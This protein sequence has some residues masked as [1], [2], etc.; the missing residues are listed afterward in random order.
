MTNLPDKSG[1]YYW[2]EK[3]GDKWE[4]GNVFE[5]YDCREQCLYFETF[6]ISGK[7]VVDMGGQWLPVPTADE[8]VE[9]QA[10][11]KMVDEGHEA[12]AV[13]CPAGK[14]AY[15]GTQDEC[16]RK[17]ADL[18]GKP[19]RR[20]YMPTEADSLDYGV[21]SDDKVRYHMHHLY[22]GDHSE[23]WI[24]GIDQASG[25]EISRYPASRVTCIEWEVPR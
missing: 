12:W 14:F 8:L 25:N 5:S 11:K 16:S 24:V 13:K 18:N 1:N 19:I 17:C 21:S 10:C 3:D 9:L 20:F 15:T 23:L 4:L 6:N 22:M 7:P 2:R